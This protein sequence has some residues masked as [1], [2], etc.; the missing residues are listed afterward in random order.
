MKILAIE[1]SCDE[2]AAAVIEGNDEG[3]KILSN[4]VSSQIDLH[5]KYGGVVP[6]LAARA[7]IENIIPVID[8]ALSKAKSSL[9]DIDYLAVTEGPGLIG[10]LVVGVETAKALSVAT[11]LPLIPVNHLEGHIYAGF[12]SQFSSSNFQFSIRSQAPSSKSRMPLAEAQ[13]GQTNIKFPILTLLVSGGNT[14][15]I[16]MRDHLDYE[17]VGQT[18][19][20]AAGEAFDKAAKAL[21][22]GYPGGPIIS[23]L[24]TEGESDKYKFPLI[25]LTPKPKRDESGYIV[26]PDPSLNFSFSGLKTALLTI[27]KNQGPITGQKVNDLCASYQ[28]AIISNLVQNSARAVHRYR[29]A[30]FVLAGGVAANPLLRKELEETIKNKFPQTSYLIPPTS[31]CGDNAAMIGLAAYYKITKNPKIKTQNLNT[32]KSVPNLKIS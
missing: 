21:G 3:P 23:R 10:S 29:P 17:V 2:T 11:S 13:N 32:I 28:K 26:K 16:L 15:L 1:S 12:A 5:S 27:I 7:H 6:E 19:D 8:E 18:I 24:A 22:L 31:L 14:Q 4:I 20:D 30:T 9:Q 25:D